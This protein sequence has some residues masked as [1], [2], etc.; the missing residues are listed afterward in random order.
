MKRQ[1][2][3]TVFLSLSMLCIFALLC[4]MIEQARL[5]GSRC[6]WQL[7]VNASLD[8]LFSQYHCSLWENY[9]V[10]GLPYE[11]DSDM[12]RRLEQYAGKYLE[13]ENWYPMEL[14]YIGID[15]CEN[16][17]DQGGDHLAQEIVD[18][19]NYGVW[20]SVELLPENG[21]ALLRDIREAVSAG[22]MTEVYDGQEKEVGRL[23]QAAERLLACVEEQEKFADLIQDALA[24]DDPAEFYETAFEFRKE[25]GRMDSLVSAYEKRAQKLRQAL[26]EGD[27]MLEREEEHFQKDRREQF[28]RQMNPYREYVEE[29]G[30]RYQEILEQQ[31]RSERNLQLLREAEDLVETL[32]EKYE[33]QLREAEEL[34]AMKRAEAAKG[35]ETVKE[36]EIVVEALS[37]G[38][39]EAIWSGYAPA[40][41]QIKRQTVDEEKRELLEQVRNLVS[42]N[43]L[44]L[45]LPEEMSVSGGRVP[46]AIRSDE[47]ETG[48]SLV[49]R[50]PAERILI[51]EYCGQFFLHAMSEEI[52]EVQYELEYILY[53]ERTDRKNLEAVIKRLFLVRQGLNLIHIMSDGMKREEVNSLAAMIAGVTGFAPL[54]EIAAG[55]IMVIWAMGEAVMDLRVLMDGGRI[56]LWKSAAE[57]QLSMEGL[58][59]MGQK[60]EDRS[61]VSERISGD[62]ESK[63]RGLDYEGYL[64]LLLLAE[65]QEIQQKRMLQIIQM[66]LQ[67]EEP[68]FSLGNC[69]YQVDIRGR[70]FGK[71]VF[72]ALPFVENMIYGEKRYILEANAQK[73]Y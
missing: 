56:P 48:E 63:S 44:E 52:R 8:T 28:Q 18:Y 13:V 47:M 20:D 2:S 9:R 39:A 46:S 54:M 4:V 21:E 37:L 26:Q 70:T 36:E 61:L 59:T 68:G 1:G 38:A 64:K 15:G 40:K 57:W 31:E 72:F 32:E 10:L 24:C 23:E 34:N 16:L 5:A 55:F 58:L 43:L 62:E 11:S 12:I 25:A 17:T 29:D 60:P 53:G 3:I 66:N 42:G 73:R 7:A 30:R 33:E 41:L 50:N 22:V 51:N 35:A 71:H 49:K 27:Q 45:V 14:E 6:Y 65:D 69:A 67:R 19:M